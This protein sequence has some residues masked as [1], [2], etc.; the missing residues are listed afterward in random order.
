MCGGGSVVGTAV[1]LEIRKEC[2]IGGIRYVP[3][4]T[5][6][7]MAYRAETSTFSSPARRK[8][9]MFYQE[10]SARWNVAAR[11]QSTRSTECDKA[12]WRM[13]R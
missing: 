4:L 13:S 5:P 7:E 12:A 6:C 1:M 2:F 11:W 8:E 3:R 9:F 10:D